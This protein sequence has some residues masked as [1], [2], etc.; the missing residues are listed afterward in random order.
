MEKDLTKQIMATHI[1]FYEDYTDKYKLTRPIYLQTP[2]ITT[3]MAN[4]QGTKKKV[5]IKRYK[6]NRMNEFDFFREIYILKTLSHP[7]IVK[8]FDYFQTDKGY[9][10]IYEYFDGLPILEFYDNNKGNFTIGII[11][12]FMY[13]LLLTIKYIHG[14]GI[15]HR[16]ID[17]RYLLFDGT[18]FVLVGFGKAAL[19]DHQALQKNKN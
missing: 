19:F 4:I 17:P 16:N 8:I 12:K 7:N 9:F 3:R 2:M 15:M 14:K 1:P 13:E 18:N 5:V 10:I 6:K 11:K